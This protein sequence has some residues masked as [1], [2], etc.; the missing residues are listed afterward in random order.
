MFASLSDQTRVEF[1]ERLT[2][3]GLA[4]HREK[5][6]AVA[7][8]ALSLSYGDS[9]ADAPLGV[10]RTGGPPDLVDPA[11][12]K[13]NGQF[14]IFYFQLNL[15]DI[16]NPERF[17]LP[18]GGLLSVYSS[19]QIHADEIRLVHRNDLESLRKGEQP[20]LDLYCDADLGDGNTPVCHQPPLTI[21]IQEAVALPSWPPAPI[22]DSDE[23]DE[24]YFELRQS[25]AGDIA[26]IAPNYE[27]DSPDE[28]EGCRCLFNLHTG[29][30][31]QFG[32]C[33]SQAIFVRVADGQ[34]DLRHTVS[35]YNE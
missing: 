16:S 6:L 12:W 34:L 5:L 11:D 33:G 21:T 24:A 28:T 23:L 31:F 25:Y 10:S 9:L 22:Y 2:K 35:Q 17:G 15:A 27:S 7:T 32:D 30:Y 19:S 14:W 3:Y 8:P 20:A 13:Q 29:R 1:L 4:D 26:D 18:G